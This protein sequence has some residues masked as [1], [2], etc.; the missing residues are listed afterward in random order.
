M[1]KQQ[2]MEHGKHM[3]HV[4]HLIESLKSKISDK[5]YH[6]LLMI[7]TKTDEKKRRLFKVKY[8]SVDYVYDKSSSYN[9]EVDK[10]LI[11][12][13]TELDTI[14]NISQTNT[15][16]PDNYEQ[17]SDEEICEQLTD[18]K[19]NFHI[20]LKNNEYAKAYKL[21]GDHDTIMNIGGYYNED[22][23]YMDDTI[24]KIRYKK[25]IILKAVPYTL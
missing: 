23:A 18:F 9:V 3:E 15:I 1:S 19:N 21:S 24:I 5:D 10:V 14:V 22:G 2:N 16:I 7:Y 8:V 12:S 6:D 20:K 25:H 4:K 11:P 13:Y 17:Y